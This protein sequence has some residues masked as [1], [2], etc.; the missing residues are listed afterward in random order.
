[1]KCAED[2]L[3]PVSSKELGELRRVKPAWR[4]GIPKTKATSEIQ[5]SSFGAENSKAK[6][7][8]EF[9]RDWRR[10]DD[11]AKVAYLERNG[12]TRIRKI[13]RQELDAA[14][15][16]DILKIC[17]T[18]NIDWLRAVADSARFSLNAAFVD[19]I[20]LKHALID[21]AKDDAN[22]KDTLQTAFFPSSP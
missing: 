10:L 11:T 2:G 13:W 4:Q 19:D 6:N 3:V 22:L 1:V 21:K 7:A 18:L 14:Q 5:K 15:L 20:H 8:L 17:L 9:A 12:L 16:E